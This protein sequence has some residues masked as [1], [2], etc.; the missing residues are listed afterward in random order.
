MPLENVTYVNTK[1]GF[2]QIAPPSKDLGRDEFL[3][4]LVAQLSH[5][6]PMNPIKDEAFVA[7]LAQFSS[8][9]QLENMNRNMIDS[10]NYDFLLSQTIS[11]T[12]AT[13]LI[14]RSVRAD[15]SQLYLETAGAADIAVDLDKAATELVI[16]I[17]DIDGNV[18]RTINKN[19]L[20]PG[21]HLINWDGTDNNGVQASSGVYTIDIVAKDTNGNSFTPRQYLEGKVSGITYKEGLALLNINGQQIPLSSVREVNEG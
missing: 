8:L 10:L 12:M 1:N 15:S 14:G 11:N 7:Q 13:S 9:E 20:T 4:L 5:Q 2:G 18:V 3:R 16:T 17:K 6:D 19:G 21:D